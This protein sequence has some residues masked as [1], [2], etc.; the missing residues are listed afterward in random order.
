MFEENK[1]NE[2]PGTAAT[3]VGKRNGLNKMPPMP[4]L[5]GSKSKL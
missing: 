5:S 1:K 2:K 3:G 4:G